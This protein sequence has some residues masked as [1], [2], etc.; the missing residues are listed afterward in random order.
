M[1]DES[2]K[3]IFSIFEANRQEIDKKR[4]CIADWA[5]GTKVKKKQNDLHGEVNLI[6]PKVQH[7]IRNYSC[8]KPGGG[9]HKLAFQ[10][11]D[12]YHV[13]KVV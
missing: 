4:K 7:Q 10:E 2:V 11:M 8:K 13:N 9:G 3:S 6:M 5:L 12:V 1:E